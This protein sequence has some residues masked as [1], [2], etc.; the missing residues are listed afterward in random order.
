MNAPQWQGKTPFQEVWYSTL[1]DNEGR[2]YWFRYTLLAPKNSKSPPVAA[3][4][5]FIFDP[6]NIRILNFKKTFAM[7]D[8]A[9]TPKEIRLGSENHFKE[10]NLSGNIDNKIKW[11]LS[12][13]KNTHAIQLLPQWLRVL[14]FVKTHFVIPHQDTVFNGKVEIGSMSL[15]I[16]NAKGT[17]AHVWGKKHAYQWVWGHCNH[18]EQKGFSFEILAAKPSPISPYITF[19]Y[20]KTP[21]SQYFFQ[22]PFLNRLQL[23][24]NRCKFILQKKGIE[25]E[26]SISFEKQNLIR[27]AYTDILEK[28]FDCF[29]TEIGSLCLSFSDG[30]DPLISKNSTHFEFTS[31]VQDKN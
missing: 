6:Q 26:G 2:G 4:W 5:A 3:V 16:Q 18:F 28:S 24:N 31:R 10:G 9:F 13:E 12:Y 30:P 27:V 14:P 29:N 8:C 1:N 11:N 17:Q 20:L 21:S 15:N 23:E 22:N 7:S 25:L 19:G